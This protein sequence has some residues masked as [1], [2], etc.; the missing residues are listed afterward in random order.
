MAGIMELMQ[1][2]EEALINHEVV[3]LTQE[4]ALDKKILDDLIKCMYADCL[5]WIP[6]L[7]YMLR[8]ARNER[9]KKALTD[10]IACESGAAG[11]I[12]H[13]ALMDSFVDSI[14]LKIDMNGDP[15]Y[16]GGLKRAKEEMDFLKKATEPM[17]AGF[18][19]ATE[20]LFPLMLQKLRLAVV[21]HY[22][23]ADMNYWDTHIEVDGDEHAIWMKESVREILASNLDFETEIQKGIETAIHGVIHVL[24][25]VLG[26]QLKEA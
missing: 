17:K 16:L 4:D 9:F 14:G 12:A 7:Q 20:S 22:P 10:N 6:A 19:F 18:M 1:K 2:G 24:D 13:T 26:D 11:N 5:W 3:L 8:G 15:V 23:N 21:A 25:L